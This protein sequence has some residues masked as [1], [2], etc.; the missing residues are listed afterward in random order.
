[1][2][3]VDYDNFLKFKTEPKKIEKKKLKLYKLK[4]N[5][6]IDRFYKVKEFLSLKKQAKA[7]R[8]NHKKTR[9][10][11]LLVNHPLCIPRKNR[12][13]VDKTFLGSKVK[14]NYKSFENSKFNPVKECKTNPYV[15]FSEISKELNP[16]RKFSN[17]NKTQ[18]MNFKSLK[19]SKLINNNLISRKNKKQNNK[20][21]LL[22]NLTKY[23]K[24]KEVKFLIRSKK[25]KE[26][27]VHNPKESIPSKIFNK[28]KFHKKKFKSCDF[29]SNSDISGMIKNLGR[30][31]QNFLENYQRQKAELPL[32]VFHKR[33]LALHQI[34]GNI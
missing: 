27:V 10:N 4:K 17:L 24:K 19:A 26:N 21:L 13:S 9:R 6:Q 1:M 2:N 34:L 3:L 14:N 31:N 30:S 22:A 20:K 25:N 32:L 15:R 16:A 8:N 28:R 23:K 11:S 7:E 12:K 29:V 18:K 5:Q 33:Y